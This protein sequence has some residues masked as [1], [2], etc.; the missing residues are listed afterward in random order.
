VV[1]IVIITFGCVLASVGDIEFDGFAYIAGV[2]SVFAQAGY[3]TL[4]EM[5][6]A[7]EAGP[8][9]GESQVSLTVYI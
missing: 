9:T 7:S 5:A 6:S 3:L 1:S 4:I 8:K 2:T